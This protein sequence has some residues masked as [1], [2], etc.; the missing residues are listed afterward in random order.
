MPNELIERTESEQ[1][2]DFH[3][4]P[5]VPTE[6]AEEFSPGEIEDILKS[7]EVLDR[8]LLHSG[9]TFKELLSLEGG[10]KGLFK[11]TDPDLFRNLPIYFHKEVTPESWHVRE[12]MG[13]LADQL[14]LGMVP[15]VEIREED[16]YSGSIQR[17]VDGVD[18]L[19][20]HPDREALLARWKAE[21]TAL[22]LFD[23]GMWN[24]DRNDGN[25]LFSEERCIGVDHS[26]ILDTRDDLR[27]YAPFVNGDAF[28]GELDLNAADRERL[29]RLGADPEEQ[30][31]FRATLTEAVEEELARLLDKE[32]AMRKS[33]E[34]DGMGSEL[35]EDARK[36]LSL[37]IDKVAEILDL[38]QIEACLTR[39]EKLAIVLSRTPKATR[40]DFLELANLEGGVV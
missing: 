9:V 37:Q 24:S 34:D 2:I 7:G 8:N 28:D 32:R 27:L 20:G 21:I 10:I 23:Y 11:Y 29:I 3:E 31:F 12:R 17:W 25:I 16:G 18:V 13:Y 22:S 1:R 30:E 40:K 14:L 19:A 39:F 4:K 15:A 38:E 6:A 36:K 35:L 26:Y 33:M 5:S